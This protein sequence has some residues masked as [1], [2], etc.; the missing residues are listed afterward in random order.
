MAHDSYAIDGVLLDDPEGRWRLTSKTE[1]PQW[2]A[3][4]SPSA[5]VPHRNGV[6][7]IAPIAS[8]V[9]TVKLEILI[10]AAHQTAGLRTFRA[11]T[12]A[13]SLHGM[14]WTRASGGEVLGADVRVSS[15]VSVKEHGVDGDLLISFTVEAVDGEW[16]RSIPE[17]ADIGTNRRKSFPVIT[18]KDALVPTIAVKADT[19]GGT[20]TVRDAVGTSAMSVGRVPSTS[21]LMV[22]TEGWD[23]RSIPA[24]K[25]QTAGGDDISRMPKATQ[26]IPTLSITPGGFRL[27]QRADGDGVVEVIGGSAILW[28]VGAY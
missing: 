20:V 16:R 7:P 25:E 17:K 26:S 24:G 28:W 18:G 14:E 10:L 15:S 5:K 4:V 19:D 3:M 27:S 23:V 8:G 22:D 12:G 9:S 21:W 13:R 1:L 2:G 6:L 11:I